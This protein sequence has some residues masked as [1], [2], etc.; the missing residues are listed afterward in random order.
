[1]IQFTDAFLNR[2]VNICWGYFY[3]CVSA[4]IA[5]MI[6]IMVTGP[7]FS[8]VMGHVSSPPTVGG[9]TSTGESPDVGR[10]ALF[11]IISVF[12]V[13]ALALAPASILILIA[14][15]KKFRSPFFYG[16]TGAILG[17][18]TGLIFTYDQHLGDL[19]YLS[20]AGLFIGSVGG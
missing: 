16:G 6:C 11:L 1:L 19:I 12:S 3:A 20:V 10:L 9:Q 2:A 5:G 18:L 17:G 8:M 13:A 4:S 14:E 15:V 7:I